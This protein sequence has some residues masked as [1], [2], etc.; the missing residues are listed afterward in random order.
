MND[1]REGKEYNVESC[2][3]SKTLREETAEQTGNMALTPFGLVGD[4][5]YGR[6]T[7]GYT[8]EFC[9]RRLLHNVPS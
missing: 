1:R 6:R 8:L 2:R 7:Y 3:R 9:H 4:R 5:K